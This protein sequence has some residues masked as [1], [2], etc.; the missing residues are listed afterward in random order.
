VCLVAGPPH[1]IVWLDVDVNVDVDVD[2][3]EWR[4][5]NKK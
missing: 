3:D 5:G 4:C 1:L 2:V